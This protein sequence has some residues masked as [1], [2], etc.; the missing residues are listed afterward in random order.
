MA[1]LKLGGW[2]ARDNKVNVNT[3]KIIKYRLLSLLLIFLRMTEQ[4]EARQTWG[5]G[6]Q[7]VS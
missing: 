4:R 6:G 3:N 1:G 2:M 7:Q 5:V